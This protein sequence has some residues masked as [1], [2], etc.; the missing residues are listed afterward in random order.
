MEEG[1]NGVVDVEDPSV[2][3]TTAADEVAGSGAS[4][5]AEARREVA[6]TAENATGA[7]AKEATAEVTHV[8]EVPSTIAQ[9]SPKSRL[10]RR[11][12]KPENMY[13]WK[14]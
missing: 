12:I 1:T 2:V 4:R 13:S 10:L 9:A 5:G 7:A 11:K 14:C 6:A 8:A 3:A